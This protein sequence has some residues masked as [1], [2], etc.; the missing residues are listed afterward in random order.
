MLK[1][2]NLV[3]GLVFVAFGIYLWFTAT[4]SL[5]SNSF[6]YGIGY[7]LAAIALL[8]WYV[9]QKLE[10]APWSPLII[11]LVIG[12]LLLALPHISNYVLIWLFLLA[13]LASAGYYLWLASRSQSKF[14]VVQVAIAVIAVAYGIYMLFDHAAAAHALTKI[15]AAFV[16]FNGVSYVSAA[17]AL[18]PRSA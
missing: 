1:I 13:F 12:A 4:S 8:A 11:S 10:P 6:A 9:S 18:A 2:T 14:Q 15:I 5:L 3:A 17:L 16:V 7:L